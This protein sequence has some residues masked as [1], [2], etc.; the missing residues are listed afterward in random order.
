MK[1]SSTELFRRGMVLPL[2]ESALLEI[3]SDTITDQSH[4][5]VVPF[6]GDEQFYRIWKT[7]V[8]LEINR[9]YGTM[10]DDFESENIEGDFDMLANLL[11]DASNDNSLL[12][13]DRDLLREMR[14][15]AVQAKGVKTSL[16]FIF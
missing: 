1:P 4:F 16:F 15:L 14:D 6:T 11:L 3:R 2:S 12:E 7:G 13:Q 8:F 5:R 9:R 10:I